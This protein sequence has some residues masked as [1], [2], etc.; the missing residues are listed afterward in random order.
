MCVR[1]VLC[2]VWCCVALGR[3]AEA[4]TSFAA[5]ADESKKAQVLPQTFAQ[6]MCTAFDVILLHWLTY[7]DAKVRFAVAES[8]G[9]MLAT[10]D[11]KAFVERLN[12]L[13]PAYLLMYKNEAWAQHLP[14]SHG[15]SALLV[16][17]VKESSAVLD[18][19]LNVILQGTSF[20]AALRCVI[21]M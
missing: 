6:D 20:A 14:I 13:I 21:R 7:K 2:V 15:F 18:P 8:L 16:A 12:K 11:S 17:A 3:F 19:L 1:C 9:Y 4:Y 5:N 10:V